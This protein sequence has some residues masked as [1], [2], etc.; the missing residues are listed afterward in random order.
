MTVPVCVPGDFAGKLF[1]ESGN[2]DLVA[3]GCL[4]E[5]N[6]YLD[7]KVVTAAFK[8][9]VLSDGKNDIQIACRAAVASGLPLTAQGD[10]GVVIHTSRNID[11]QVDSLSDLAAAAAVFARVLVDLSCAAAVGAD[12]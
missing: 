9:F 7:P 8:E 3:E 5:G 4:S 6:R 1:L 10:D 2:G 11:A 12:A